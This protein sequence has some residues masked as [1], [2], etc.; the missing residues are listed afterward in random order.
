MA[1]YWVVVALLCI[2]LFPVVAAAIASM[3]GPLKGSS[4]IGSLLLKLIEHSSGPMSILQKAVIPI[5]GLV[6]IPVLWRQKGRF[7]LG[8][9]ILCFIGLISTLWMWVEL[10]DVDKAA[11]LWQES[12]SSQLTGT[13]FPAA[14]NSY[15]KSITVLDRKSVV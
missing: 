8:L 3:T 2:V 15:M 14:M 6:T 10:S 9:L 12:N 4:F 13:T 1:A 11:D 7:A 5:L